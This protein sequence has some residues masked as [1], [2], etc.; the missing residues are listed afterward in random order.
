M[1]NVK[2]HFIFDVDAHATALLSS[3]SRFA[4]AFS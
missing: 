2:F 1:L 3:V 4:N